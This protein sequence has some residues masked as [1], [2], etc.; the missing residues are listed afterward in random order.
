VGVRALRGKDRDRCI[1]RGPHVGKANGAHRGSELAEYGARREHGFPELG[2]RIVHDVRLVDAH[3]D[4]GNSICE[5]R[6]VVGD[7]AT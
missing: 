6:Q 3:P 7:A 4:A 1:R 5:H 2:H